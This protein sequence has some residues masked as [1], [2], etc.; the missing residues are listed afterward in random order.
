MMNESEEKNAKKAARERLSRSQFQHMIATNANAI[1]DT[2][3]FIIV[4]VLFVKIC[5]KD[6]VVCG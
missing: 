4:R 6:E 5:G 1:N 2:A 3:F